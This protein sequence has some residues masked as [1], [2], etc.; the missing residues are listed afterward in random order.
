MRCN[1]CGV[2][3]EPKAFKEEP[4]WRDLK[5]AWKITYGKACDNNYILLPHSIYICPDCFKSFERW[6]MKM[7][8][9]E[10]GRMQCERDKANKKAG[11][12]PAGEKTEK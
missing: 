3:F 12:F 6:M 10:K 5:P 1:R 4:F 7:K 11:D 8:M 2:E 9:R